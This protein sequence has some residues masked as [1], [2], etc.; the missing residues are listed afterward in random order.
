MMTQFETFHPVR[1]PCRH[2][3]G[4]SG[5]QKES[6]AQCRAYQVSTSMQTGLWHATGAATVEAEW[7]E[8][9]SCA[10]MQ[11]AGANEQQS[12][13]RRSRNSGLNLHR[14]ARAQRHRSRCFGRGC[15]AS[16][17]QKQRSP[18][19]SEHLT[20]F[21]ASFVSVGVTE[22]GWVLHAVLC[23]PAEASMHTLNSCDIR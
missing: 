12:E 23:T 3:D 4:I 14:R 13:R 19:P 5:R 2:L 20:P 15:T 6:T 1:P 18:H 7:H 22:L 10:R 9:I 8:Y 11:A 21:L 16:R 17:P